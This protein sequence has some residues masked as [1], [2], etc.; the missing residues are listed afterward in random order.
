[1]TT[2]T[3][4]AP[5]CSFVEEFASLCC[6][7]SLFNWGVSD[8][9][10]KDGL[11]SEE[12]DLTTSRPAEYTNKSGIDNPPNVIAVNP[13]SSYDTPINVFSN[14]NDSAKDS[15]R[16]TNIV[17]AKNDYCVR[18]QEFHG[19]SCDECQSLSE[20]DDMIMARVNRDY[21]ALHEMLIN[22]LFEDAQARHSLKQK[23]QELFQE[24]VSQPTA[25]MTHSPKKNICV[26]SRIPKAHMHSLSTASSVSSRTIRSRA[27]TNS[28]SSHSDILTPSSH[29][30]RKRLNGRRQRS[31]ALPLL[32]RLFRRRNKV[33]SDKKNSPSRSSSSLASSHYS[34]HYS[35][36]TPSNEELS[37]CAS[38]NY[39]TKSSSFLH[40]QCRLQKDNGRGM[41]PGKAIVAHG[42]QDAMNK[43]GNKIDALVEMEQDRNWKSASLTR[44][45][46]KI[47]T[48]KKMEYNNVVETRSMVG[49]KFGFVSIKYGVLIHWNTDSGQAVL[50]LLRKM[51]FD[52]FLKDQNGT[53]DRVSW[54]KQIR[55]R[56]FSN[57]DVD[58][59]KRS[60][61]STPSFVTVNSNDSSWANEEI[62]LGPPSLEPIDSRATSFIDSIE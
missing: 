5:D 43:L 61:F 33:A 13:S 2:V 54:K 58:K 11:A 37:S 49:V 46:A 17:G 14:L 48:L 50:I 15:R 29:Q 44:V 20:T 16:G 27:S 35:V 32:F 30:F 52:N 12:I 40:R 9:Q 26:N 59:K 56:R 34:S 10:T 7:G 22:S 55:R 39:G 24:L 6:F 57:D 42:R 31:Y 36:S 60:D 4:C 38:S 1:M 21:A 45:P 23:P 53:P 18:N 41:S 25:C 28:K 51:C 47:M 8:E 19:V 62:S 3:L